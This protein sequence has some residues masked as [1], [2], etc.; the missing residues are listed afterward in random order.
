MK[1]CQCENG[2]RT[3]GGGY[4]PCLEKAPKGGPGTPPRDPSGLGVAHRQHDAMLAALQKYE[5]AFD[6]LFGQCCSN[7]VFD[8]W[9]KRVNCTTL[10]E[11]H[12]MAREAIGGHHG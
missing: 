6:L 1:A 9:G 3:R 2:R 12:E 5:E 7:G 8:A 10:N 4:M 11:A